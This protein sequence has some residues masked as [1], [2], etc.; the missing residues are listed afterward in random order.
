MDDLD[1]IADFEFDWDNGNGAKFD[2]I[3]ETR[4]PDISM[5]K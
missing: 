5:M 1:S 3:R 2:L 4:H